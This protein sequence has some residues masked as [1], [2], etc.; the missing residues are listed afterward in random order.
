MAAST[1]L[2]SI[3]G[4][5]GITPFKPDPGYTIYGT[6][7]YMNGNSGTTVANKLST[8]GS[9]IKALYLE[10]ISDS[11]DDSYILKIDE[12]IDI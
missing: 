12:G 9:T 8:I 11:E 2:K 3:N 4:M 7:V 5:V 1:Y 10:E 6:N